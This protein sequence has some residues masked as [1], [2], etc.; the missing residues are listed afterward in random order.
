MHWRGR[1]I[2]YICYFDT[3]ISIVSLFP[4]AQSQVQLVES[5]EDVK[6][7]GDSLR[8]SCKASGFTFSGSYM[9]WARQATGKV[10][11]WVAQIS[12]QSGIEQLY[13]QAVKG[14]FTIS[15]DNPNNLLYLQMSAPKA[16]A[17]SRCHCARDTQ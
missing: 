14:R 3:N 15:R 9:D 5:R 7:P 6:R 16:G 8:L 10:L 13:S 1:Q 12:S 2:V 11:Q 4:G 17:T